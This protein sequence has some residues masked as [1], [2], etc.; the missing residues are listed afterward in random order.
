MRPDQL[1]T[2]GHDAIESEGIRRAV[3]RAQDADLKILLFDATKRK[4]DEHTMALEDENAIVVFN[5]RDFFQSEAH[6]DSFKNSLGSMGETA[7]F[8]SAKSDTGFK[9]LT[10]EILKRIQRMLGSA[11]TPSLTRARHRKA[12]EDALGALQRAQK[13]KLPELMAE[14]MRLAVRH[15]GRITGRVDVEDL[16]D[17][18]FRDFCIGK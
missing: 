13:A 1:G 9:A 5:K 11:E 7:L 18:I 17:V 10:D 4:L 14:D 3:Q 16:L 8:V 2:Q 15:I 12:L 6:F